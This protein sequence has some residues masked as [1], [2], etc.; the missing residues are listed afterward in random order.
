MPARVPP[1]PLVLLIALFVVGNTGVAVC[2]AYRAATP[3]GFLVL[4]YIG[5]A[6]ALAW[7]VL[8]DCR[9]RGLP[10]SIDHGWFVFYFWPIFIPYHVLRTR[11]LRGFGV[12]AGLVA[13]Y[14]GSYLFSLCVF[15]LLT[16]S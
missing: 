4:Y 6:W 16:R 3:S 5:V 14:F 8:S 1:S 10:T 7:W 9:S 15:F 11:G 13:A 12:L 2:S